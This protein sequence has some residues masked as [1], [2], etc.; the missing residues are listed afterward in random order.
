MDPPLTYSNYMYNLSMFVFPKRSASNDA[1]FVT[2]ENL[3]P[4]HD[5]ESR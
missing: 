4:G 3:E 1:G 5:S 2:F